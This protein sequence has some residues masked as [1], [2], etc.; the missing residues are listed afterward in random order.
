MAYLNAFL[1]F[2]AL[3]AASVYAYVGWPRG[4]NLAQRNQLEN[5]IDEAISIANGLLIS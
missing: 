1:V 2:L 5:A 3:Y 4:C